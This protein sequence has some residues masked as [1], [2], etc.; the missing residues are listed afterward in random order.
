MAY[1]IGRS[2]NIAETLELVDDK[3]TVK[4]TIDVSLD[5]DAVC[6]AFR[7]KQIAIIDAEK[8]LKE[9]QKQGLT[10]DLDAGFE[11]YGS[12]LI[13]I[14]QLI[15]GSENT[16]TI[17]N[18]YGNNYIEISVQIVPYIYTVIVPKLEDAL[19]TKKAQ[20]KSLYKRR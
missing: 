7:K 5:A 18:F 4:H 10:A 8:R 13:D 2:K 9:L 14:L 17:L 11:A 3:G 12:A 1:Q 20:L 15:F 6:T 19:K 16:E